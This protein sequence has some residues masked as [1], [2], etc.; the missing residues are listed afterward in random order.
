MNYTCD[1]NAVVSIIDKYNRECID[2]NR[3]TVKIIPTHT[4]NI[5]VHNMY[6]F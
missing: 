1:N 2:T 4:Y 6:K 3:L 5:F